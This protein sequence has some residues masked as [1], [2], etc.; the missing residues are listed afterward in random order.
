LLAEI[1]EDENDL[2]EENQKELDDLARDGDRSLNLRRV[3]VLRISDT[4]V[5]ICLGLWILRVP[6][7]MV[8]IQE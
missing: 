1:S 6:Y 4:I 2:D 7:L 8:D 5:T 3:R